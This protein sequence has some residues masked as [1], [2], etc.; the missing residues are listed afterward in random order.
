MY[1]QP[2]QHSRVLLIPRCLTIVF[3]KQ[4]DE[5]FLLEQRC[6]ER[7]V[8][9]LIRLRLRKRQASLDRKNGGGGGGNGVD[10][11]YRQQGGAFPVASEATVDSLLRKQTRPGAPLAAEDWQ[12]VVRHL[13]KDEAGEAQTLRLLLREAAFLRKGQGD[14]NDAGGTGAAR[15][16]GKG[17]RN[18]PF[19]VFLQVL[20]G[21]QLHRHLRCL[22]FFTADFR[23]VR[24]GRAG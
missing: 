7:R 3:S 8:L 4:V 13:Y 5:R 9:K 19:G 1:D 16:G 14:R 6:L 15:G 24:C 11:T 21:Y 23:E 2:I 22:R 18:L 10:R 12:G 20:L 17:S